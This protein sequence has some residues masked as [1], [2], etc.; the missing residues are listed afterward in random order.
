MA[1]SASVHASARLESGVTVDPGA[2]IGPRAAIGQGSVIGAGAVIGPDVKIGRHCS[3]G[4]GASV[5]HALIG[6]RV[7]IH[8]GCRIGGDGFGYRMEPQGHVKVPQVGRVIVQDEVEIGAGTTVDRGGIR[9]TVIGEGSKIDNL[10]QIGHNVTVGRHCII[11]AQSGLSGSVTLEDFVVLGAR[12]GIIEHATIGEGAQLAARSTVL[13]DVP[14]GARW[15]GLLNAKP[16]RQ[17]LPRNGGN[18]AQR[19]RSRREVVARM[20]RQRNPGPRRKRKGSRI[21]LC[22][23]RATRLHGWVRLHREH[24]RHGDS[25]P[26][27]AFPDRHRYRRHLHRYRF[28]RQP[29]RRHARHQGGEHAVQSGDRPGARGR[30]RP[31]RDRRIAGRRGGARPRHHRRHQRAAARRNQR[32][33]PHRHGRLPPHPRDRPPV[34]ARGL[35]QFLFL[36]KAAAAGAACAGARGRR[37]AQFS[38]RGIAAARRSERARGGGVLPQPRRARDRRVPH[39]LLRQSRARAPGRRNLRRRSIRTARCRSPARCCR[40]TANTSARSPRWSTPSSSRTWSAISRACTP[41]SAPA[42]TTSRSW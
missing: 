12:V 42:S 11:V 18:R 16:I 4:P 5:A 34:G 38:R 31:R 3:I 33:R 37:A 29:I 14:R 32:A 2:M 40:N 24:K 27:S 41:S 1:Q 20:K 22:I 23:V 25:G 17:Y 30:G 6:D 19:A 9:D 26:A 8:A 36:G 21:A 28:G 15:G 39:P 35:R 13:R 10:V 7:I